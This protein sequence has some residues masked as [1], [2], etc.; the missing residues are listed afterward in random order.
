MLFEERA[1]TPEH[2][3][4]TLRD[5]LVNVNAAR[6]EEEKTPDSNA[7]SFLRPTFTDTAEGV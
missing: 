4:R 2:N 3:S 1:P 5:F 6:A 7:A